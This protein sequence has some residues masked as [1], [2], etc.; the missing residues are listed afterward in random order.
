MP[1]A[2]LVY[3]PP[4]YNPQNVLY[5]TGL[6][7]TAPVGTALPSDQNLGVGAS[8]I[9]GGW[10]YI[11]ATDAGVSLSYSPSTVEISIEE[12]STPVAVLIDKATAEISFDF[13]EET[14]E[15]IA[16]AYGASGN[17]AV[18]A[19]GAGQPGKRVLSLSTN[20]TQLAAA[21]VGQNALG[22]AR[23]LSIPAVMSTGSV[24]TDYRRAAN[25]RMYPV[26]LSSVCLFSAIKWVDL[27]SIATS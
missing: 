20:I 23:V 5:G 8:W 13:N 3:S 21:I 7:F 16:I 27:T 2:P 19:A 17:I 6:A 4:A 9:S 12:Q 25:Q 15:N 22:F 10:A 24:K 11:G 18:T 26:T 1:G 14:L